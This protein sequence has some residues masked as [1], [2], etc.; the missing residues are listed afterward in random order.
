MTSPRVP[1]GKGE[2]LKLP[3]GETAHV[4]EFDLGMREFHCDCGSIHAVVMDPHPPERFLPDFLIEVLQE[5]IETTSDEMPEFGT[6]HLIGMVLEEFPGSVLAH[7]AS[8]DGDVGFSLL[9]ITEF[10]SRRLHEIIV[11][12]VIE[13]MEHAMS[14]ADDEQSLTEFERQ[15]LQFDVSEFVEEYRDQRDL[16]ADDVY[17]QE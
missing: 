8:E 7:D 10:D 4:R 9:W 16:E 12:L 15:M 11:E 13:L 3:C 5:T 2:E 14:H 1:G 6:P 17:V